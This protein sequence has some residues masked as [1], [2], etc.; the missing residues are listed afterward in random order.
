[1]QIQSSSDAQGAV[2]EVSAAAKPLQIQPSSDLGSAAIRIVEGKGFPCSDKFTRAALTHLFRHW[3]GKA[4]VEKRVIGEAIG[5][6]LIRCRVS[7]K[8]PEGSDLLSYLSDALGRDPKEVAIILA[9]QNTIVSGGEIRSDLL[10]ENRITGNAKLM[11][12]IFRFSWEEKGEKSLSIEEAVR[13]YLEITDAPIK[14]PDKLD[15]KEFRRISA[16]ISSVSNKENL[17]FVGGGHYAL[18]DAVQE[19]YGRGT[20]ER[21]AELVRKFMDREGIVCIDARALLAE[22]PELGE[23]VGDNPYI[24]RALLFVSNKFAP[25]RKTGVALRNSDNGGV[26]QMRSINDIF[27]EYAKEHGCPVSAQELQEV[28]SKERRVE[29]PATSVIG[30]MSAYNWIRVSPGRFCP[31]E[32]SSEVEPSREAEKR[33]AKALL[34]AMKQ[35]PYGVYLPSLKTAAPELAFENALSIEE[36]ARKEGFAVVEDLVFPMV[37]PADHTLS[38][39]LKELTDGKDIESDEVWEEVCHKMGVPE[40][41]CSRFAQRGKRLVKECDKKEEK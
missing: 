7:G 28:A 13:R 14:D 35:Y 12:D 36:I 17:V 21:V 25:H 32:M 37:L 1:L 40:E 33:K 16:L 30:I 23:I 5:E 34:D 24:L 8:T 31:P 4:R 27:L 9:S 6:Y 2:Y 38:C 15:H 18:V 3:S 22:I 11:R 41:K 10:R 39:V 26:C 19:E 20:I 29:F